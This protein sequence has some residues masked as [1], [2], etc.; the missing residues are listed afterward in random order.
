MKIKAITKSALTV[1]LGASIALAASSGWATLVT[2]TASGTAASDG[3][4]ENGTATFNFLSTTQLEITL[5]NTAGPGQLGG[6]SSIFDGLGFTLSPNTGSLSLTGG[7][8]A[9][10]GS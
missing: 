6:I 3:R 8:A 10:V 7:S 1:A 2:F 4:P 5:N 9:E